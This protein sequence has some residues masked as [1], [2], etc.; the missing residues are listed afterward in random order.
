MRFGLLKNILF[1]DRVG[2]CNLQESL[3]KSIVRKSF[4][5]LKRAL[6]NHKQQTTIEMKSF[7]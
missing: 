4:Y 2:T 7:V 3:V 5:L 1:K 6:G